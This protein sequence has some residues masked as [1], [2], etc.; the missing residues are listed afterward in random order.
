[1]AYDTVVIFGAD[2][3]PGYRLAQRLSAAGRKIVAVVRYLRDPSYLK[4]TGAEIVHCDPTQRDAVDALFRDRNGA[5]L[6]VVCILGGTPQLNTQGNINVI[7]AAVDAGVSRIVITTSIGCGDSAE[8]LD[9]FVKAVAGRAIRAKEWAENHL[10]ATGLDWTIVRSGGTMRRAGSGEAILTD[11]TA[12]T[13]YINLGD[14]G[15]MLFVALESDKTIGKALA[16]VD[17]ARAYNVNGRPL[18][19]AEV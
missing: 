11:S 14:L 19:P 1:M 18:V 17:P 13:G 10:R 3:D 7:D 15:D 4:R 2:T 16:A 5:D 8:I 9:P 12:V 6:A